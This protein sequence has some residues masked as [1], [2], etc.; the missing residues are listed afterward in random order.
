[1]EAWRLEA[2][3]QAARVRRGELSARHLV[4]VYLHR[5]RALSSKVGAY[6]LV[7]ETGAVA[8]AEAVDR[9]VAEGRDPG[10][11]AGVCV[12]L[13]DIFVTKGLETTCASRILKGFVSPYDSTVARRLREAG[14]IVLGKLN[15]D[16]FAMGSSNE[17]SAFEACRNPWDLDRVPGGSSGGSAAA[18]A[19][20]LCSVA[21]GTDTGGSIRQP[22]AFCGVSGIK[23]TYGRISRYGMIAF[24]SS[25]DQAGPMARSARDCA[26]A[27]EVLAGR[28]PADSTS[29][30]APVGAYQ[31]A[32]EREVSGLTIGVPEEYLGEGL[33]PQVEAAFQ[34]AVRSLERAGAKVV[35][36][37]LPHT[38]YAVATYYLI[39]PAEASSNLAR[40]DGV[41]YGHRARDVASLQ[42]M[43]KK[44]RAEGFG[45]EVKRR[46][47]LG[48][49]ALSAGY[50]D[51]YYLRAQKVRTL[52]RRD[53]ARA[54]ETCQVLLTPATPTAAFKLG[55]KLSDPLTMYL[56]DVFT[57]PASLAGLPGMTVP[58][59]RTS[60]G[61]PVGLQILGPTLGEELVFAVAGSYQRLTDWH[62]AWPALAEE[63]R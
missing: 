39:A 46:I 18:V 44:T 56:G 14:A 24:A 35:S 53:F 61:L 42:E 11:L 57:I 58:C 37:S 12:G 21:I 16:E 1:M 25:L 7:D 26:L 31:E 60:E 17:H 2:H 45:P 28:D 34:E 9:A 8:Q 40:Y 49:Y 50:Y 62:R 22:A 6:L 15:M 29:L 27:L 63:A 19:A 59:G 5:I 47:M 51:A 23:P 38:K 30:D 10:P 32:T 54:F 41:R 4:A 55:E 36:V 13:K 20:G 3:E 43:Y 48:T 33:D 52:I